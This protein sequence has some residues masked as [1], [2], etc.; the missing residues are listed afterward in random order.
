MSKHLKCCVQPKLAT[1]RNL[2]DGPHD[3]EHVR[4]C[5]SCGASWF[6]RW[7]EEVSFD[8]GADSST[9]WYTRLTDVERDG[10]VA[11]VGRPDLAFLGLGK[12]PAI[13]VDE[14]GVREVVGAPGNP[15]S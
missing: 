1:L 6:Q 5:T 9:D 11:A 2:Y 14:H 12:R 4:Q 13:C 7:H 3:S 15:R 8:G 10:L